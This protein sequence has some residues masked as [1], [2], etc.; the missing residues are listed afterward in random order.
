M[1]LTFRYL[2]SHTQCGHC[3]Q[4]KPDWEKLS[5]EW[6][7]N[8]IGLVAE[9]DCTAPGGRVLCEANDI[10][11]VPALKYG[12]PL[13]L[14]DYQG[15]RDY[16]S[17]AEFAKENLKRLCSPSNM[18]LCDDETKAQIEEI[19]ALPDEEL[20]AKITDYEKQ[21]RDADELFHSE[22]EKLQAS[23][24]LLSEEKDAK[25]AAV[26][27]AGLGLLK[28]VKIARSKNATAKDEL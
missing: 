11:G 26:K 13:N 25:Q 14:E 6:D 5:D 12:D 17:L 28:S 10:R 20:D 24:R 23:F 7:G 21:L 9:I 3:K 22:I 19:L 4:I 2:T 16:D 15:G 18:D 8:D 27:D 1:N